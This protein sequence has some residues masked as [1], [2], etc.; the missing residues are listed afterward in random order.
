MTIT[1]L[2]PVQKPLALEGAGVPLAPRL[3]TLNGKVLGLWNN[4]KMNAAKLLEM[5]REELEKHYSFTVVRGIYDPGNL[6]P[7]DG[8]GEIDKC[9]VVL[10]ANGDCGACST[11]GIVNAIELEKRGIPTMLTATPPFTEAVR[12]S[13]SLRGMPEIQWAIVDHPIASLMED[14][15]RLRAIE[16]VRQFPALMLV[17]VAQKSAA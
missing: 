17:P 10:L 7:E 16:A 5:M 14:E 11:S 12:T 6:M 15:L 2:D 1:V 13:A 9:D 3:D 4:D 8:W